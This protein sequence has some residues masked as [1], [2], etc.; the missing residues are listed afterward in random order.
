MCLSVCVHAC[1][2]GI[3]LGFDCVVEDS[4]VTDREMFENKTKKFWV[5]AFLLKI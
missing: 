1:G 3:E 2:R 5:P 4:F